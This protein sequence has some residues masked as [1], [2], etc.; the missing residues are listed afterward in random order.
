[1]GK[2]I[3]L[4]GRRFERLIVKRKVGLYVNGSVLWECECDC[5]KIKN[6]DSNSLR[7]GRTRSCGCL[8]DEVATAFHTKHGQYKTKEYKAWL[9]IKQR[10]NNP[11]EP[12]F[13][14]YGARGIRMC[15]EW[16][17]SFEEFFK[18]MGS[19]PGLKYSIE[20][21]DTIEGKRVKC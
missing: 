5:G 7:G 1:M 10:C 17:N 21:I 4:T 2:I 18:D 15:E 14:D 3:D 9:G 20:R 13:I 6:V 16:E 11:N 12:S 19:C 8:R